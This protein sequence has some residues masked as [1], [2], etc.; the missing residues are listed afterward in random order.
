M[1]RARRRLA[2]GLALCWLAPAAAGA[3]GFRGNEWGASQ[4]E[5]KAREKH[6]AQRDV[7]GELAYSGF[8][9][10]GVEAGLVYTFEEDGLV[11]AY[12]LSRHE[13]DDPSEHWADYETWR[14]LFDEHFGGHGEGEKG[15]RE[16]VWREGV[17]PGEEG[18]EAVTSGRAE[19]VTRWTLE[20]SRVRL[21]MRG[22]EGAVTRIRAWF[23]PLP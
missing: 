4:A 18:L 17:E 23:E 2:A 12:Y 16:W 15:E 11:G 9:L 22:E 14:E 10:A 19:L 7:P 6:E 13:T 8:D 5:V 3:G 1:I 20:D 21:V